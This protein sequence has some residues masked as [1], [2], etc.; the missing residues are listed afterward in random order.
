MQTISFIPV[1]IMIILRTGGI[2]FFFR[3]LKLSYDD[4]KSKI[5]KSKTYDFQFPK[6]LEGINVKKLMM[7][8]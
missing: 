1:T 4:C 8:N 6:A 2:S 7:Q 5:T 3:I